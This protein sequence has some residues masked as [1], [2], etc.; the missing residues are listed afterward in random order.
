ML[1][2]RETGVVAQRAHRWAVFDKPLD[3][4]VGCSSEEA[5]NRFEHELE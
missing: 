3:A 1:L 2:I 4:P 5:F